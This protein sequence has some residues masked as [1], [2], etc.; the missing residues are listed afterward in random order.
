MSILKSS[1]SYINKLRTNLETEEI[2][3]LKSIEYTLKD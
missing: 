1:K 3:K 2:T